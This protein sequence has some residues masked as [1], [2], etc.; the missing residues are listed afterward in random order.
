MIHTITDKKGGQEKTH[1][2]KALREKWKLFFRWIKGSQ[3][4][5]SNPII[6][7]LLKMVI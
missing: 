3:E 1:N 7:K 5:N 2:A 6:L 4:C